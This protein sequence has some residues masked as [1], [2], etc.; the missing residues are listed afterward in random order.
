[1]RTA[2]AWKDLRNVSARSGFYTHRAFASMSDCLDCMVKC[3]VAVIH[4]R[5]GS[6]PAEREPELPLLDG[7]LASWQASPSF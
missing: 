6:Q 3:L 4:H 5:K 1:M 2:I 7:R